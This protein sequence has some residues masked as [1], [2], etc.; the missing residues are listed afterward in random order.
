[1]TKI[2]RIIDD[3]SLN[4]FSNL[5]NWVETLDKNIED[6]LKARLGEL[7]KHWLKEFQQWD[8]I[9]KDATYINCNTVHEIKLKDQ[10]LFLDPPLEE[11]RAFWTTLFHRQLYIIC[12]QNRIEATQYDILKQYTKRD[13][14]NL[15]SEIL[16][17]VVQAYKI[18]DEVLGQCEEYVKT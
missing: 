11:A 10:T 7:I 16:G 2:Q 13:Y 14:T 15:L 17:E 8:E 3:L 5:E 9:K 1:M 6:V 4:D 18:L 12:G